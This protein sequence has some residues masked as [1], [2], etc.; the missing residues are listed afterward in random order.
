MQF[1]LNELKT[2]ENS[3]NINPF[4]IFEFDIEKRLECSEC[5]SVRYST[6]RTWYLP[7]TVE[8]LNKRMNDNNEV[9]IEECINQYLNEIL[10]VNCNICKKNTNHSIKK[11]INKFSRIFNYFI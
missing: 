2:F 8:D 9:K 7:L 3:R 1:F 5:H 11:K 10:D 6:S 4:S